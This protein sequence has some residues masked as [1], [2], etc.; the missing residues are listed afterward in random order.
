M[1]KNGKLKYTP[2]GSEWKR[3]MMKMTK[4][5]IVMLFRMIAISNLDMK[6]ELGKMKVHVSLQNEIIRELKKENQS[7]ASNG[8]KRNTK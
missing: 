5:E 7:L 3:E 2:Y 8:N 6:N 1:K 4:L